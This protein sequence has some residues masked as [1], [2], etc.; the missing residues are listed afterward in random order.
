MNE[1]VISEERYQSS[2]QRINT[3]M[4]N[5]PDSDSPDGIELQSLCDEINYDESLFPYIRE[6][7]R[8][9]IGMIALYL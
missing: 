4:D 8:D 5:D 3:L 6:A 7:L 1:L 2:L 9:N